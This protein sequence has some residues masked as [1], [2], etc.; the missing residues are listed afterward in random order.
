M[1]FQLY[2]KEQRE[3]EM[4]V[5]KAPHIPQATN[6]LPQILVEQIFNN[7]NNNDDNNNNDNRQNL[8][9]NQDNNN[10]DND[11]WSIDE[12]SDISSN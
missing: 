11:Q 1:E 7:D 2:M 9:H 4:G 6:P 5:K 8:L 10:D 3:I 12:M